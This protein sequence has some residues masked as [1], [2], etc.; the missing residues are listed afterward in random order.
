MLAMAK[1][2]KSPA[3]AK[4][5]AEKY[6]YRSD[7]K[8]AEVWYQKVLSSVKATDTLA[9]DVRIDLADMYRRLREYDKSLKSFASI[10]KDFTGTSYAAQAAIY[11]GIVNAKKGDNA[12][13]I[14]AYERYLKVYPKGEDVDYAKEQIEKLNK[15]SGS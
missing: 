15:K 6:K 10:E 3:L 11:I 8:N 14:A 13:A 7:D 4:D 9:A 2:D 12:A 5:I 1:T